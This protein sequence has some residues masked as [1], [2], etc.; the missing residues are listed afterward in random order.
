MAGISMEKGRKIK[1]AKLPDEKESDGKKPEYQKTILRWPWWRRIKVYKKIAMLM[2][3][4]E[5][6]FSRAQTLSMQ[7][8][9][10]L[11][12]A[13]KLGLP[14]IEEPEATISEND[15]IAFMQIFDKD[16]HKKILNAVHEEKMNGNT[17]ASLNLWV[18]AAVDDYLEKL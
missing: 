2:L 3:S 4:D 16:L 12:C 13:D 1:V 6:G 10:S 15:E 5:I 9:I 8:V 14:I 18:Q 7:K 11:A 17:R